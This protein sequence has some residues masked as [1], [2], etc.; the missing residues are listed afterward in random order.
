M[1]NNEDLESSYLNIIKAICNK[2]PT[3]LMLNSE[4]LKVLLLT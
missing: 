1:I 4:K 2:P 3:T